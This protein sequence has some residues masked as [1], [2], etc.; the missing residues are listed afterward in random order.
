MNGNKCYLIYHQEMDYL[1]SYSGLSLLGKINIF[2]TNEEFITY[3][4]EY[5]HYFGWE[6]VTE[7]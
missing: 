5:I 1:G 6:V 7:L 2:D 3:G 4:F